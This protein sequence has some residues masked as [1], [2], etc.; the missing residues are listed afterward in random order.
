MIDGIHL[1][2]QLCLPGAHIQASEGFRIS[3]L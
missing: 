1:L 2:E 3:V